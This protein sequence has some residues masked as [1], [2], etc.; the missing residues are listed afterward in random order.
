M[1]VTVVYS[2]DGLNKR[3]GLVT[4][5]DDLHFFPEYNGVIVVQD[6]LFERVK[7][8]APDLEATLHL[9]DNI[10]TNESMTDLSYQVDIEEKK[11][12]DVARQFLV[13]QGLLK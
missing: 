9:L 12:E 5:E 11:L 4:L 8:I 13:D 3:F 6:D 2:T 7:D 10:F 1:D